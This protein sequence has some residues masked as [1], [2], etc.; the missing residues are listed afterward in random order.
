MRGGGI[1]ASVM[2]DIVCPCGKLLRTKRSDTN[3]LGKSSGNQVC[4]NCKKRVYW[5]VS[6]DKAYTSYK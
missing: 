5:D 6:K 3:M 4:P 2:V 1:M